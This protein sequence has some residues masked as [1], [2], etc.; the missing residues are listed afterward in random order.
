MVDTYTVTRYT[1]ESNTYSSNYDSLF[2]LFLNYCVL[3]LFIY[4]IKLFPN[5]FK[6]YMTCF[7]I[8]VLY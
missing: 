5:H 8:C 4:L 1:N 6:L 3:Y 7:N 2:V